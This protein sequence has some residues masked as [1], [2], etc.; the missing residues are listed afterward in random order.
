MIDLKDYGFIR[1]M[2]HENEKGIPGRIIAVHKGRYELVC[3]YGSIFAMLKS[4]IY[5]GNGSE[6]FPT[7]GDFVLI[8]HFPDGDSQII[9]TLGR[10]SVFIR[11]NM[12]RDKGG[13]TD[14]LKSQVLATNFDYVFIIQSLNTDFNIKRL[15]RYITLTWQSN[16]IPIIILN[17]A[18]LVDDCKKYIKE[19][20]NIIPGVSVYAVSAKNGYGITALDEYMKP[21]KTIVFLG[22]S[23]VGKSSLVNTLAGYE[24]MKVNKIRKND[25][26]GRHT[27]THRQLIMLNSGVMII[28]TPGMRELGMWDVTMGIRETFTDVEQFLGKC[29][30]NDCKHK[31]EP[32]CAVKLAIINGELS[33]ERWKNYLKLMNE[34]TFVKD[35]L[36]YLDAKKQRHKK[37]AKWSKQNK[38]NGGMGNE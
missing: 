4:S 5:Y 22:S 30:F 38:K 7:T 37:L 36:K 12:S 31:R 26:K 32:G 28:D 35:K 19:V 13:Y 6:E 17:K 25:S 15:E 21:R 10:K 2:I 16:A 18:D 23:G 24:I 8:N 9:K 1:K 27:T 34:A 20:E 29:K 3:E 14:S 11:N 33:E